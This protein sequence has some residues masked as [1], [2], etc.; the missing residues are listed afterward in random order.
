MTKS[1]KRS[2]RSAINDI[3]EQEDEEF[4]KSL[5]KTTTESK[6]IAPCRYVLADGVVVGYYT[7]KLK[8]NGDL[9]FYDKNN[10]LFLATGSSQTV[11][12]WFSDGKKLGKEYLLTECAS[13]AYYIKKSGGSFNKVCRKDFYNEIVIPIVKAENKPFSD[14]FLSSNF[15]FEKTRVPY[16]GSVNVHTCADGLQVWYGLKDKD[17][18]CNK[19]LYSIYGTIIMSITTTKTKEDPENDRE[20]R[21]WYDNTLGWIGSENFINGIPIFEVDRIAG[22]VDKKSFYDKVVANVN[23]IKNGKEIYLEN[24]TEEEEEEEKE[25]EEEFNSN[26]IN[27]GIYV[28][29]DGMEIQYSSCEYKK[30][31][32]NNRIVHLI[33]DDDDIFVGIFEQLFQT[34]NDRGFIE[35]EYVDTDRFWHNNSWNSS[36]K[37]ISPKYKENE[38]FVNSIKSTKKE[39]D[40]NFYENIMINHNIILP[41]T[42]TETKEDPMTKTN[43]NPMSDEPSAPTPNNKAPDI[44][45]IIVS[46]VKNGSY[47][48]GQR[49]ALSAA[50]HGLLA[51]LNKDPSIAEHTAAFAK[52][53]DSEVG[54]SI[55]SYSMGL[56]LTYTPKI[57]ENTHV[58]AIAKEFRI[59]GMH[60]VGHEV[61]D[62]VKK[63]VLPILQQATAMFPKQ[64]EEKE[65]ENVRKIR[66]APPYEVETTETKT[67]PEMKSK[68]S[69]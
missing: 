17:G 10:N 23:Y 4:I 47:R 44:K 45:A 40:Q 8:Y 13:G 16:V 41:T 25:E 31:D 34:R 39:F 33:D 7:Y 60:K 68:A 15:S 26:D 29:S 55:L 62:Q 59:D 61:A 58:A 43:E 6:E 5:N 37:L 42:T 28:C 51:A 35:A 53:L 20:T 21:L 52:V 48:F 18:S 22:E 9:L 19:K 24:K 32:S 2:A 30:V 50:K 69:V 38:Y 57:S 64:E 36:E 1:T 63:Y 66:V 11:R 14:E 67:D 56:A 54:T 27:G 12:E 65:K 49:R 3:Q 46:D